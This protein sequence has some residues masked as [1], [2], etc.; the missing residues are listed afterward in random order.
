MIKFKRCTRH[1]LSLIDYEYYHPVSLDNL[2]VHYDHVV[3]KF[4][5]NYW[6]YTLIVCQNATIKMVLKLHSDGRRT[7]VWLHHFV[8]QMFVGH[9]FV[10]QKS[11]SSMS[12]KQ[13]VCKPARLPICSIT[14]FFKTL[15]R[16]LCFTL[17]R[18][19]FNIFIKAADEMPDCFDFSERQ[20]E[21]KNVLYSKLPSLSWKKCCEVGVE[22]K[23]LADIFFPLFTWSS[24]LSVS[25]FMLGTVRSTS[26][27]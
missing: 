23:K 3:Y 10:G 19:E 11:R 14:D 20:P 6:D 12:H 22:E 27:L 21:D 17:F 25:L 15:V 13:A 26:G 7:S 8:G 4:L 9:H 18:P 24:C 16:L 2:S 1:I 5:L